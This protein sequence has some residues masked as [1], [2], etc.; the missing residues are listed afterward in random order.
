MSGFVLFL[1]TDTSVIA[2]TESSLDVQLLFSFIP[3]NFHRYN[4]FKL[5]Y[6]HE[7]EQYGIDDMLVH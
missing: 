4:L 6:K 2:I 1:E 5:S 3:L 7:M